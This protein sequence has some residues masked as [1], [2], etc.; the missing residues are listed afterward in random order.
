MLLNCFLANL[1][2]H[3]KQKKKNSYNGKTY[4][5]H[6]KKIMSSLGSFHVRGYFISKGRLDEIN[7]AEIMTAK[8]LLL[9][10]MS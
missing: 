6:A 2:M 1:K 4:D 3:I 7:R 8:Y 9:L 5:V 10:K